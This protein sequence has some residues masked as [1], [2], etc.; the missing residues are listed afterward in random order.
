VTG[1]TLS[2]VRAVASRL[3]RT[4]EHLIREYVK[5]RV[6]SLVY[7]SISPDEE[8]MGF[9]FPKAERAALVASEPAKF[10]MPVPSDER[11]NWVR[12]RLSQLDEA[13]LAELVIEAW[14]MCVPAKVSATVP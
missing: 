2:D 13:E 14:R 11:Y 5:F 10:L 8:L 12:V 6:G 7:A 1:V 4:S 9:A 3:P